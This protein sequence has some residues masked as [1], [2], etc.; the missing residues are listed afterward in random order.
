[1]MSDAF[2]MGNIGRRNTLAHQG[3]TRAACSASF[4]PA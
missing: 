2:D 1:M 4:S 3:S